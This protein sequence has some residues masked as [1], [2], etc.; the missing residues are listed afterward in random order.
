MERSSFITEREGYQ[1]QPTVKRLL[2][3]P[4]SVKQTSLYSLTFSMR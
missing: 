3:W 2:H 1:E 4:S